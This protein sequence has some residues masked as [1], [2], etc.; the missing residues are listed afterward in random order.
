M[1]GRPPPGPGSN[2][3]RP[4][5]GR[6]GGRERSE[7]SGLWNVQP[8]IVREKKSRRITIIKLGTIS[9]R[10]SMVILVKGKACSF[11]LKLFA[12]VNLYVCSVCV[13]VCVYLKDVIV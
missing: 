13:C 5:G 2:V 4:G 1:S 7:R 3:T 11:R 9:S 12:D 8:V 6:E 10:I